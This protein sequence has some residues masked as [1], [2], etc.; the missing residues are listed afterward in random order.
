MLSVINLV[1]LTDYKIK[2]KKSFEY[3]RKSYSKKIL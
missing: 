3:A 2:Y 1:E